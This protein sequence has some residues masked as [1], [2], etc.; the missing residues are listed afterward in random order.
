MG[1][2]GVNL[3]NRK[4][5]IEITT[6]NSSSKIARYSISFGHLDHDDTNSMKPF[7]NSNIQLADII[8]E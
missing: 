5:T 1:S 4:S 3:I 2:S 7:V 8:L 6:D